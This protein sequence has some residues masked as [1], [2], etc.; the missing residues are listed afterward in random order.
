MNTTQN[1]TSGTVNKRIAT[2]QKRIAEELKKTPIVQVACQRTGIGRATYY[3][4][5]K[6]N[7]EFQKIADEALAEGEGLFNDLGEHQLM[8]LMKDKHWPAIHYWLD[9]RHPKFNKTN[10]RVDEQIEVAFTYNQ[11]H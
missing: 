2:D 4:W 9:K 3:R 8:I 1:N 11:K 10:I 7:L 6:E 5:Y